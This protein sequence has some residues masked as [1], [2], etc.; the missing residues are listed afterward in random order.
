VSGYSVVIPTRGR[1]DILFRTIAAILAQDRTPDSIVVVDNNDKEGEHFTG[2]EIGALSQ[3]ST[4][5]MRQESKYTPLSDAAG[6]Q[7]GLEMCEILSMPI[8]VKWDDDLI[9]APDCLGRLVKLVEG[10]TGVAV[11]GMYPR[12]EDTRRTRL[13]H[14][15]IKTGDGDRRHIQFFA[16]EGPAALIKT[17]ALYSSFAYSVPAA[18]LVGGFCLRYSQ[19]AYRHETDFTLRLGRLG[20]LIVDTGAAALHHVA[21]GGTRGLPQAE[22][23]RMIQA[24]RELFTRRMKSMNIDPDF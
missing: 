7:A 13:D 14:G 22:A 24:D 23:A 17:K 19:Y 4:A 8:A 3:R 20:P 11:G 12:P 18:L 16:W 15:E 21:E 6:S 9:P 2:R 10:G 5:V 1:R